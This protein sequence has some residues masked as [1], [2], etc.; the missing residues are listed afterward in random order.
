MT[1]HSQRLRQRIFILDFRAPIKGCMQNENGRNRAGGVG[2]C[3]DGKLPARS[4]INSHI[5]STDVR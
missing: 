5:D 3:Q 2:I 4:L 1:T